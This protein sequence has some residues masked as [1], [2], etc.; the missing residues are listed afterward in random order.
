MMGRE[1]A[2]LVNQFMQAGEYRADFSGANLSS[3]VYY[4]T[5]KTDEFSSIKSMV[6]V[7]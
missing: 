1:V 6:L 5:L 7:K 3:G 2:D 4:Y